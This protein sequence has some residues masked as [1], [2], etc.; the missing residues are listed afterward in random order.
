M[1]KI[2]KS[3]NWFLEKLNQVDKPLVRVMKE[4]RKPITSNKNKRGDITTNA[5][6]IKRTT[7][8]YKLCQQI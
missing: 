2:K 6:D 8:N 4:E 3:K 7:K 5:T 1:D